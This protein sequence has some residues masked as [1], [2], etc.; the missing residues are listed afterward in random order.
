VPARKPTP[1][2]CAEKVTAAIAIA[3]QLFAR[4]IESPFLNVLPNAGPESNHSGR[5]LDAAKYLR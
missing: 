1:A 2:P 4:F 3:M 5:W